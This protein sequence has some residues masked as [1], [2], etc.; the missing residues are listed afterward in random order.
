MGSEVTYSWEHG[1]RFNA[2]SNYFKKH[3]GERIQ[4]VSIDA[5]FTCPNRDGTKGIGGCTFCNNDAFN[6]SYCHPGKSVGQQ[7]MEGIT[8]H[9]KRYRRATQY[10][11]YFQA[12][13][14]SYAPLEDLRRLYREAL[15]QPGVV[16]LVIGTRPDCIDKAKLD[17]FEEL[18]DECI[19]VIEF[20]IESC[21]DTTLL[22]I[23]RGHTFAESVIAIKDTADRGIRCGGH[24]IIGLPGETEEMVL[25]EAGILSGLPLNS[26]KFHQLQIIKETAMAVE[27]QKHPEQFQFY[28]LDDYIQLMIRFLELLDPNIVV[29]RFAGEAPPRLLAGPRWGGVR[30]DRIT[31][32]VEE[33]MEKLD[34]WQGKKYNTSANA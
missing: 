30:G 12:Y 15:D 6:P 34:T 10:L 13:S 31:S 7:I 4:K 26:L 1:R 17:L 14:N 21:Y 20:G 16:G 8:F 18:S 19:L 9:K 33:G 25:N 3:Y 32:L 22:R 23:N 28:D 2:Y 5:G 24:I 27:Y 29:E 11:A